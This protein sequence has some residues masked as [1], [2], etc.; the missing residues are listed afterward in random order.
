MFYFYSK[1]RKHLISSTK[2]SLICPVNLIMPSP[3]QTKKEI[4]HMFFNLF[5]LD[6]EDEEDSNEELLIFM[7]VL[8]DIDSNI[9]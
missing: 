8:S 4:D 6:L 7:S 2:I 1:T 5:E 9:E 3:N